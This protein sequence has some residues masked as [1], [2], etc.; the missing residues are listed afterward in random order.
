MPQQFL[1]I[2]KHMWIAQS[3]D[4]NWCYIFIVHK[5]GLLIYNIWSGSWIGIPRVKG[6]SVVIIIIYRRFSYITHFDITIFTCYICMFSF[7]PFGW[8]II[9]PA[10]VRN[11]TKLSTTTA[12]GFLL[13]TAF[14]RMWLSLP[15]IQQVFLPSPKMSLVIGAFLFLG[16]TNDPVL[17]QSAQLC[18]SG[19]ESKRRW[20]S[21]IRTEVSSCD[22]MPRSPS[23]SGLICVPW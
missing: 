1:A 4:W 10:F 19:L 9:T 5:S 7:N 6:N 22:M 16:L 17:V 23:F 13:K 14:R 18:K 2:S 15:Q 12:F 8:W 11:M 3:I 20:Y 21:S